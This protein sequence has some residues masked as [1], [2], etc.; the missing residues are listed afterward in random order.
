MSV[1][2]GPVIRRVIDA[3]RG[4]GARDELLA[5][6]GLS[7]SASPLEAAKEIVGSDAYYDLLERV[8]ASGD[9]TLPLRY[10]ALLQPDDLG[11]LGLG[12]KTAATVR[13]A[14]LRLGRYILVLSDTLEYELRPGDH[15]TLVMS[16]PSHRRGAQLANECALGAV[17][18]VLRRITGV[19]IRPELVTFRH[20]GPASTTDH[21]A[22]FGCS[23]DFDAD[24]NAIVF[25][26]ETLATPTQLGDEGLSAF[27]L[28]EL[29]DLKRSSADRS[30]ESRVYSAVTD[31]L[32]DGVPRRAHIARRL[33]MSERTLHRRLADEGVSFASVARAAQLDA[34]EA[35]LVQ[36]ENSLGEIAFLTGFSDQSAFSRAF[37]S[38]FGATPL[39][40]RTSCASA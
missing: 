38:H 4:A 10:A 21:E 37:R 23:V 7:A 36:T 19:E 35:L 24:G 14:L 12:L 6:V 32:P 29:D 3:A 1:V 16:R 13:E 31:A 9:H 17:V 25:T 34:A 11:A 20:P 39:A 22:F 8:T 5:S 26:P 40:Y 27:L 33:G 2:R 18:S 30:L 15:P 28:A